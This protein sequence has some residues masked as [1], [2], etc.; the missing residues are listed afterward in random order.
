MSVIWGYNWVVMKEA[1]KY[2][3]PFEFSAIRTFFG[4]FIL[5]LVLLW[6]GKSIRPREIPMTVLL[7]LSTTT[8]SVGLSTWALEN[9]SVGKTA[10]LVY[11][12]PFWVIIL[13]WPIL[14]ERIRGVQWIAVLLALAGLVVMVE[15]W[16]LQSGIFS[17][18][19]AVLAGLSWA[20]SAIVTKLMRRMTGIELISVTAWQMI[21]GAVPLASAALIL[22]SPPIRWEP[23]FIGAIAYNI[24]FTNAV[25]VLLWFYSLRELPAGMAGMGTLA[26]PVIGLIAAY[27][28]LGEKPSW[29]ET[30]GI[31]L[32]MAALALISLQEAQ[33]LRRVSAF[34]ER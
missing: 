2:A 21:F 15:P 33:R 6:K 5:L 3:S 24:L 19:L 22:S 14:A 9:G 25:A 20:F 34:I 17:V 29:F 8:G 23:Y 1:L 18:F 26:T 13:A 7:G 27:I 28:Q 32:I 10:V 30:L 11:T 16:R 12:M 31:M 4:G